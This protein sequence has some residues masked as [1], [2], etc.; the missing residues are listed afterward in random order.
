MKKMVVGLVCAGV[1]LV[2][3]LGTVHGIEAFLGNVSVSGSQRIAQSSGYPSPGRSERVF[4]YVGSNWNYSP[5]RSA[6]YMSARAT[7]PLS[8]TNECRLWI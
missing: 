1:F 8:A 4:A 6:G 5:Y 2:S 7:G 3:G